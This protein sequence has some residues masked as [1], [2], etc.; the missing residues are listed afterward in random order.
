MTE[1]TD[2]F[3]FIAAEAALDPVLPSWKTPSLVAAVERVRWNSLDTHGP[4]I[5]GMGRVLRCLSFFPPDGTKFVI[6]GQDPYPQVGKANGLAFGI[7]ATFERGRTK[8]SLSNIIA[9]IGADEAAFDTTLESWARQGVLL[10][11]SC[12]TVAPGW[13]GAHVGLGWEE[14][15]AEILSIVKGRAPDATWM[16]WGRAA[17]GL[18]FRLPGASPRAMRISSHPSPMSADRAMGAYPSFNAARMFRVN[19]SVNWKG[20]SHG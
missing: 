7:D 6:L 11:N 13:A 10:L 1:A 20:I 16:L 4:H 18:V 15:V 3:K 9:S 19:D 5:P 14:V 12:L 8:D 2:H 17:K